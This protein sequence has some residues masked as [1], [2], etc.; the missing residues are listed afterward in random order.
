M[1]QVLTSWN[2]LYGSMRR[3]FPSE[4]Y[5]TGKLLIDIQQEGDS[6]NAESL[7]ASRQFLL[8][9]LATRQIC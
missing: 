1:R 8:T 2:L 4:H 5:H 6:A 9:A 7:H 3:H